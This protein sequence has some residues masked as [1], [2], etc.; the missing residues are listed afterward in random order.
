MDVF[1]SGRHHTSPS[2]IDYTI[3]DPDMKQDS[4]DSHVISDLEKSENF[5]GH[6]VTRNENWLYYSVFLR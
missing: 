2:A 3:Y 6:Q 1:I 5:L 4:F